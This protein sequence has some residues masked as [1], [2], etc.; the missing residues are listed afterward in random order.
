MSEEPRFYIIV[1][2]EPAAETTKAAA[3]RRPV[4]G[5]EVP[6]TRESSVSIRTHR[7]RGFAVSA[8]E[9]Y[10]NKGV[11]TRSRESTVALLD[12]GGIE[13]SVHGGF[14]AEIQYRDDGR[15]PAGFV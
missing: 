12:A 4:F 14:I 10:R 9:V 8:V 5:G 15:R 7:A 1:T 13:L 2:V 6:E 11:L 3:G